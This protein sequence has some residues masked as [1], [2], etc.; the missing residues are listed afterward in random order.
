MSEKKQ[1]ITIQP[2]LSVFANDDNMGDFVA[3]LRLI[4]NALA[5]QYNDTHSLDH[6]HPNHEI[7]GENFQPHLICEAE[8]LHQKTIY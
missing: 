4:S 2:D 7:F 1:L 6:A 8:D 5:D 3:Q